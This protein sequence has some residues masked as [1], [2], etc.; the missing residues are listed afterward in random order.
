MEPGTEKLNLMRMKTLPEN[1]GVTLIIVLAFLVLLSGVVIAF[2]SST[3]TELQ[4]A[5]TYE[6]SVTVKQLLATAVNVAQGQIS[7]ATRSL[8]VP[9]TGGSSTPGGRLAWASQPGMIRTWDDA[10][11]PWR[12]FKLYSSQNMVVDFSSTPY[13]TANELTN[14]V[15]DGWPAQPA[16]FTDLNA[17]V[18]VED[19]TGKIVQNGLNFH[20]SY[21]ILD[22]LA[23]QQVDGFKVTPPPGYGGKLDAKTGQPIV[24]ELDNP[25]I[26]PTAGKSGNPVAMP[27]RWIYVLKNGTITV[28]TGSADGGLTATWD[29]TAPDY[30]PSRDNPIV[31]RYG[32][33]TDDETCKLNVNTASEP[34]PF[35]TPRA[36]SKKDLDYG[37][38]QPAQREYQRFPG[39]PFMTALSPVFFP[40][41]D[42][43]LSSAAALK[44][45]IYGIIPRVAGGGS[46]AGTVDVNALKLATAI[47]PDA[48]RLFANVDEFLF[49]P[50]KATDTTRPANAVI[51]AT[52]L[53][54]ARFF[55]TANSRA[56]ELT[57]ANQPRISLWPESAALSSRTG[58][59]KLAAFCTTLGDAVKPSLFH[60]QRSDATSQTVDWNLAR[61]QALYKYLQASTTANVPGFGGNFAAKWTTDRDQ[62]LTEIFDYIRS[63]NLRDPQAGAT[64][65]SSNGQVSPT[66]N[67]DGDT[68]GFGRFHTIS[69]FGMHFI[70][71]Q[72]GPQ[73]L[74]TVNKTQPP[75]VAGERAL[76]A[77]LLFEPF[78][79]S[80]GWYKL[81][82]NMF[83]DVKFVTPMS[84]DGQDLKMAS[85]GKAL[86][87][88]VGNGWHCGG[89]E[90][91]GAGG[92]RGPMQAF[93]G[94]D[95]AFRSKA[96][97]RVKVKASN[98]SMNFSGGT[99]KV[100]V[101]SGGAAI[102]ANLIQTF[103]VNFPG[104]KFPIP[105]LV[106]T[107]TEA[108]RGCGPTTKDFWWTFATRYSALGSVP[109]APGLEYL[110]PTRRWAGQ[111]AGKAAGFK[112]G[113]IFRQEDV[114]RSVVP[115]HGDL[116]LV[117]AQKDPG[118]S[119][120][121]VSSSL[122]ESTSARF[123]HVFSEAVGTHT[124]FGNCNE[125]SGASPATGIPGSATDDQIHGTSTVQYHY[126]RLPEIRPGAGKVFN[127]WNDLDNGVA[128]STD[129]PFINKPDEGN[130]A[131]SI[132]GYY[133]FA[134]NFG[135]PTEVYFSPNRLVPSSGMLG[136]LPTGVKRNL[137][138]QTLLFRPELKSDKGAHPGLGYLGGKVALSPPY[139]RPPD[140]LIMDHF[141]MPVI[142]PYA[143]SEPFSTA[144]K[145]NM[146]YEIAPFSYI[147][148]ATALHGAMKSE[149]VLLI[150]NAASKVY[151]LWDHETNDY[152]GNLPNAPIDQ[153]PQVRADWDK[154]FKGTAP[155]DK[156]RLPINLTET[157]NQFEDRFAKGEIFRS[158]TQICEMHL[159]RTG[160]TLA[161]YTGNLIYP[162]NLPTGDNS[163][164]RP[165]ANLYAKLTT[166]SNTFTV[167]VRAQVLGK[168]RS[169][170]DADWAKWREGHDK[171]VSEYR[172]STL[173]ERYIDPADPNLS[174]FAT[175]PAAV[176]DDAYK[177]R[178]VTTKRFSP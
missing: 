2:F 4:G 51:N 23:V 43:S 137:P 80:E 117:A 155:F 121:K 9:G 99:I 55:L 172:G 15:P 16:L 134:W 168:A 54:H 143:I 89:R 141:W 83:F 31:G 123:L 8:K 33:W 66:Y 37:K 160:E 17:P 154:A 164:E 44:E 114:V 129:G 161:Q 107:G 21:P 167:H 26:A 152:S 148:R 120:V 105:D 57:L 11:K 88:Y 5:K 103:N 75:L 159:V 97:P 90:R 92:L 128:Q 110:Q 102:P 104:G 122:W 86:D 59:D 60:F 6:S 96:A 41:Q 56:P 42:M 145:I 69:Q 100:D 169:Q 10:G 171:T 113:G 39:H 3:Q 70:C 50:P 7:D 73:G 49:Q 157:L 30:T 144:G 138:W 29:G 84:I 178:T 72:D 116:R 111:G 112:I 22:A 136:S 45:S 151:K 24:T 109:H 34:T 176:V 1:R 38:Y 65:Y 126:S 62:V 52:R 101:Y 46:K 82:E 139:D 40:G 18:L 140:H 32:F 119:F 108:Y 35:D 147:K 12:I 68:K 132:S 87:N 135:V 81:A 156:M 58:Y 47:A 118:S 71:S 130:T 95:Y 133:Y 175:N 48:D 20:A 173:L 146:N 25:L 174:D 67:K 98:G 150:P 63:T 91:G 162:Q 165:Y 61:N 94:G 142:E 14:E 125:A 158:A 28:P 166:K 27:V 115:D 170:D 106:L 177:F 131:S 77:A 149:E 13:S 127:K 36:I 76:E 78:S 163:R 93:G 53:R 124:L 79:P 153:D 85:A 19:S 74:S 64:Y